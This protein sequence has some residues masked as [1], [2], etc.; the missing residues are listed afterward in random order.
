MPLF[1]G[2]IVTKKLGNIIDIFLE[3]FKKQTEE[4][5]TWILLFY[6]RYYDKMTG[7]TSV[8]IAKRFFQFAT[9]IH[10]KNYHK[11]FLSKSIEE[12]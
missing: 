6:H 9:S 10:E 11:V 4:L 1:N 5:F 7:G 8:I 2:S 3:N 12:L